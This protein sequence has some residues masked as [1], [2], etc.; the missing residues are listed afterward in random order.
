[1]VSFLAI[2]CAAKAFGLHPE[3]M[4]TFMTLCLTLIAAVA[5]IV[6]PGGLGSFDLVLVTSLNATAGATWTEA[7]MILWGVRLAQVLSIVLALIFF[8]IWAKDFL[9][10]EL[11]KELA[12]NGEE[13]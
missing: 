9:R 2:L 13:P 1:M 5:L 7:C 6:V 10:P 8:R 12:A 3:P 11:I 4:G